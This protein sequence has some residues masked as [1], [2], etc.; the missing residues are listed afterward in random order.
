LIERAAA[1]TV[2]LAPISA[3]AF[4][5][6]A[7]GTSFAIRTPTADE[8]R[9]AVDRA[10]PDLIA[11]GLTV[12]FCG[13]NPGLY[14]AAAQ[15]HFAR[16]GNRFWP[17][18]HRA[19][20]TA[21]LLAPYDREGLIES[22]FGITSL[23]HRATASARD[24]EPAELVAGRRRLTRTIRTYRP[25]WLAVLGVGAYR[26]AFRDPRATIG[27]Q[28]RAVAGAPTWVLPSPS[29]ANGSYPLVD[30]IRELR[31]FRD[32]IDQDQRL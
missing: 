1:G 28:R 7:P 14:S 4:G 26:A 29:G 30:L 17:A 31:A 21:R 19:G 12:L 16:P 15:Y 13:I 10:I 18:L 22:G 23:V 8:V 25:R 20:L 3:H 9:A 24:L 32:A 11:P 2:P 5:M 6:R 27:P